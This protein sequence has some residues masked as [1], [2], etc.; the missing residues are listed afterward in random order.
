MKSVW[1]ES[2][3]EKL[4]SHNLDF[5]SC[6]VLGQPDANMDTSD[7][8]VELSDMILRDCFPEEHHLTNVAEIISLYQL[9][10]CIQSKLKLDVK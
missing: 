1:R 10:K 9:T 8:V 4:E 6:L 5:I 3:L 2:A 7:M